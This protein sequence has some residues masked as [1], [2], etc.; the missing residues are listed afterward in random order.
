VN[1]E[2]RVTETACSALSPALSRNTENERA[3]SKVSIAEHPL[4]TQ[5]VDLSVVVPVY[6]SAT[7]L[8]PLFER[9]SQVC[10]KLNLSWE[11]DFVDDNSRDD[12]W[13]VLS[14]LRERDPRHVTIIQLMRNFGQHNALMCGFHHARGR[15]VVTIDDDLQNPPEEIPRLLA[16]IESREL[17]L[18]YGSIEGKKRHGPLRNLGSRLVT[19][20]GQFVFQT[21]VA[22]SSYR[23]IRRELVESILTYQLNYTFIDGL[24]AWN[25]QRIGSVPVAH[26]QRAAGQSGYSLRRLFT[27]TFNL[28]TNFSLV[29]LQVVSLLGLVAAAVGFALGLW[30]LVAHFLGWITVSGY[31]SLIVTILIMGGTQLLALGVMGEYL[32]RIHLNINRKPQ[33]VVR[34]VALSCVSSHADPPEPQE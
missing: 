6:N 26:D 4:D 18:V 34:S 7:T 15:F 32:G 17:D 27:H 11:A 5:R 16:E 3:R 10:E 24:L 33:F 31:A 19:R 13:K 23:I 9:I 30:F 21:S 8:V 29:P 1:A 12:S 14:S 25:T 28:L 22:G 20:F 2:I